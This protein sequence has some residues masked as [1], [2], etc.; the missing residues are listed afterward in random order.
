MAR[1]DEVPT[2]D[3]PEAEEDL[4]QRGTKTKEFHLR[5]VDGKGLKPIPIRDGETKVVGRNARFGIL[6]ER[7][8]AHHVECRLVFAPELA[9]ELKAIAEVYVKDRFGVLKM[10]KAGYVGYLQRGS[11]LYLTRSESVPICG[12]VLTEGSPH[13]AETT[14]SATGGKGGECIDLASDSDTSDSED[15]IEGRPRPRQAAPSTPQ[16]STSSGSKEEDAPTPGAKGTAENPCEL[17]SSDDEEEVV[18]ERETPRKKARKSA[19]KPAPRA[20]SPPKAARRKPVKPSRSREPP[21]RPRPQ[22][23][24]GAGQGARPSYFGA[25]PHPANFGAGP[26]PSYYGAGYSA[27]WLQ[28]DPST[29]TPPKPPPP[30]PGD[31]QKVAASRLELGNAWIR[32]HDVQKYYRYLVEQLNQAQ[33]QYHVLMA[34]YGLHPQP[35]LNLSINAATSSIQTLIQKVNEA[36]TSISTQ[37]SRYERALNTLNSDI[38]L[39]E[40]DRRNTSTQRGEAGA[41]TTQRGQASANDFQAEVKA[42]ELVEKTVDLSALS[43]GELRRIA[44]AMGI[45]VTGLLEKEEF[46]NVVVAKRDS[47]K[48]VWAVRKRKRAAE[49]EIASRQ[50]QK[51]A[52]LRQNESRK[53]AEETAQSPA[54]ATAILKV[55]KWAHGADL[56][57][58]LQRCGIKVDGHGKTKKALQGAYR[59]AMLKFHPDR[60]RS[61]SPA[62]QAIAAEVTK[63]ITSEWNTLRD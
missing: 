47:G 54:K 1:A 17:L 12:Y 4:G 58:F 29:I 43:A 2:G 3:D 57:L 23:Q 37:M 52:E 41:K 36:R 21:L 34:Q 60:T 8:A 9:L 35:M 49:E 14:P 55:K 22:A 63:W 20:S 48:E 16:A 59:R 18:V 61:A 56:R 30:Q 26:H 38:T 46:V 11:V 19:A 24:P 10:L 13:Q 6:D 31:S 28:P 32:L 62:D 33:Q 53:K 7:V 39:M 45:D 5:P 25:G 27:P 15:E 44:K 51:L 42:W 40:R 50:R